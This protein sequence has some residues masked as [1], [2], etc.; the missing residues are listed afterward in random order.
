MAEPAY[1]PFLL[2]RIRADGVLQMGELFAADEPAVT[3][4][5]LHAE[6]VE[7][8]LLLSDERVTEARLG[9]WVQTLL[10]QPERHPLTAR[11]L[12]P[13][14][15]ERSAAVQSLVRVL[16]QVSRWNTPAS[17]AELWQQALQLALPCAQLVDAD[18]ASMAV[19]GLLVRWRAASAGP[20]NPGLCPLDLRA[21]HQIAELP[22]TSSWPLQLRQEWAAALLDRLL[23]APA[24]ALNVRFERAQRA[25]LKLEL[26]RA[27]TQ[28]KWDAKKA[29]RG[30]RAVWTAWRAAL[31]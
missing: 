11:A 30:L 28:P 2:E 18:P 26:Q 15:P 21:R 6:L 3:A 9:W 24:V 29:G 27:M 19:H 25:L 1:H 10:A 12:A 17:M 8:A 20:H 13:V 14:L 16:E 23:A 4:R 22:N 31:G 5:V 7:S